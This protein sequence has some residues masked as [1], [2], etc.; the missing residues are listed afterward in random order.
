MPTIAAA[1][2]K[3]TL[4]AVKVDAFHCEGRQE[5][6]TQARGREMEQSQGN[7][8]PSRV[9]NR[10][11]MLAYPPQR[12]VSVGAEGPQ[13]PFGQLFRSPVALFRWPL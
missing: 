9:L 8:S 7:L 12:T 6:H 13:M 3:L 11:P 2:H 4:G 10:I 5:S 1:D